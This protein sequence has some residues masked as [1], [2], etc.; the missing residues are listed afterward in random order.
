[1]ISSYL[2][3]CLIPNTGY[4]NN[5][6]FPPDY[7]NHNI[8]LLRHGYLGTSP[9]TPEVAIS[10]HSLAMFRQINRVC[11]RLSDNAFCEALQH[12]HEVRLF[13]SVSSLSLDVALNRSRYTHTLPF[14]S[15]WHSIATLN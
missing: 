8:T 6:L 13:T 9:N 7:N 10:I 1:M 5:V 3:W 4:E 12:Y 2:V 15:A 14:S 11:P